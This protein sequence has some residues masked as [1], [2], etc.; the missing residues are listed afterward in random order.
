[1]VRRAINPVVGQGKVHGDGLF[2]EEDDLFHDHEYKRDS[3]DTSKYAAITSNETEYSYA[4]YSLPLYILS[5]MLNDPHPSP[6]STVNHRIETRPLRSKENQKD[7]YFLIK[8]G[9]WYIFQVQSRLKNL[10]LPPLW[11]NIPWKIQCLRGKSITSR[12]P[13]LFPPPFN[14]GFVLLIYLHFRR[15]STGSWL[16][17]ELI[18]IDASCVSLRG[19]ATFHSLSRLV[20]FLVEPGSRGCKARNR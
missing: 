10:S 8:K 3:P 11:K 15:I 6:F 12:I 13:A 19:A 9:D 17:P 14:R 18:C 1:M 4:C 7:K 20:L 16:I 2:R 5:E